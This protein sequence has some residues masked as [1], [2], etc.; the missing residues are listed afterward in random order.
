MDRASK[1]VPEG[2]IQLQRQLEQFRSTH[3]LRTKL[4]EAIWQAAVELARQYGV[5]SVA[6]PLRLDY[7]G[8]KRRLG[9][10]SGIRQRKAKPAFVELVAVTSSR[11]EECIIELESSGGSK[12]RIQWKTPGPP[13][14]TSLLRAWRDAER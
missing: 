2:I 14:W 7:A 4:P 11:P 6:Y 12:M 3:P 9:G 1:P 10:V 13:D 5:N 8:L